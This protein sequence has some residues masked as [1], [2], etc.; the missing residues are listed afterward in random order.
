MFVFLFNYNRDKVIKKHLFRL[1]ITS[2]VFFKGVKL[3]GRSV[4]LDSQ[5]TTCLD[6]RVLDAMMFLHTEQYGNPH[7]RTH[8]F[9]WETDDLVEES[10]EKIASLIGADQK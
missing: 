6:P 3:K 9:G 1:Y 4:Y 2:S 5:A 7:S 8:M 10:R